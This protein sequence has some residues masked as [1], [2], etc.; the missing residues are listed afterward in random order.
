MGD[1]LSEESNIPLLPKKRAADNKT[2]EEDS[3]AFG[4]RNHTGTNISRTQRGSRSVHNPLQEQTKSHKEEGGSSDHNQSHNFLKA[5]IPPIT[6]TN[7]PCTEWNI[8]HNRT[9]TQHEQHSNIP[10]FH[11]NGSTNFDQGTNIPGVNTNLPNDTMTKLEA[12]DASVNAKH[13]HSSATNSQYDNIQIQ[14]VEQHTSDRRH[15]QTG[16]EPVDG[17]AEQTTHLLLSGD[18]QA[19]FQRV[20]VCLKKR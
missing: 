14:R 7:I 15:S 1:R 20:S 3:A 4:P 16:D 17:V 13:E 6:D 11:T 9:T 10:L 2:N 19:V 5:T 8:P 18:F 12:E